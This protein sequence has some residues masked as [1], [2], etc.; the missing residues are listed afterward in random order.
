MVSNYPAKKKKEKPNTMAVREED[1]TQPN[2]C[3]ETISKQ[4]QLSPKEQTSFNVLQ[5]VPV[6]LCVST[7]AE[8]LWNAK[9]FSFFS[10]AGVFW[11]LKDF[12][13]LKTTLDPHFYAYR[14]LQCF[15]ICI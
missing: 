6:H 4:N 12:C 9:T 5:R 8:F 15:I 2:G 13:E 3:E 1:K 10:G 7:K 11:W 14:R